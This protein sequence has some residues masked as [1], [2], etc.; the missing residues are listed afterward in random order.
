MN[1]RT[2][3]VIIARECSHVERA[4]TLPHHG[5]Y[6]NG[7]HSHDALSLYLLLCP[8]PKMEVIKAIHV[9]D[10]GER[11]CGDVPAPT[12]WA[13]PEMGKALHELEHRCLASVG[14]DFERLSESDAAW[15]KAVDG[16]ELYLWAHDQRALGNLNA[17]AVIDNGHFAVADLPTEARAFLQDFTWERTSDRLPLEKP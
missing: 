12:K 16:L 13:N 15:L 8:S 14:L 3:R 4:H 2:R 7:Q 1:N 9:H 11:W 6:T 5:S 17:Q 10:Y